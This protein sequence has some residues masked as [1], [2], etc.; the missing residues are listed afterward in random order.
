M[1]VYAL[2]QE[3]R[4]PHPEL[5]D[6]SGLLAVGGDL[7]HERLL[8]AY[9][10]GIFPWFSEDEPIMWWSPDPRMILFP[11]EFKISKSLLQTIKNKNWEIKFDHNFKNV[12]SEC[13]K[14][15]R[16]DQD[17]TWI[18]QQMVDAYIK[19]HDQG[20]AHSVEVYEANELIGGLYGISLGRSF[21]GESMF[22][23][24]RDASKVALFHLVNKLKEFEF[25]FIDAQIETTHL[26]SLGAKLIPRTTFLQLLK[27]SIK[28][29]TYKGKW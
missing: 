13:A 27:E 26:K 1:P 19:L 17:G 12:I 15:P 11:E 9:S 6:E 21:F 5:A 16:K 8:L 28:H 3:L 29:P 18:T 4:F 14:V 23:K 7:S 10:N 24:K 22:F 2:T 20:F 25:K